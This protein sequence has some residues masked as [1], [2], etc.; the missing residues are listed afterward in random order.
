MPQRTGSS[1][2]STASRSR[3]RSPCR[4]PRPSG[5]CIWPSRVGLQAEWF[6]SLYGKLDRTMTES[7]TVR[8]SAVNVPNTQSSSVL[9][10]RLTSAMSRSGSRAKKIIGRPQR[11]HRPHLSPALITL[12]FLRGRLG[13]RD[14]LH[15]RLHRSHH[16]THRSLHARRVHWH[17]PWTANDADDAD[18]LPADHCVVPQYG[19]G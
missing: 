15:H 10:S 11:P 2:R 3:T 16:R 9:S 4:A 6:S 7:S 18:D 13:R 8:S 12:A 19:C 17:S 1:W 5:P 14:R